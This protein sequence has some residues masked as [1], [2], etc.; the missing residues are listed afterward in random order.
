MSK[1]YGKNITPILEHIA[2]GMWEIDASE[3]LQPYEYG[4][5]ALRAASKIMM[6]VC[7]D[8]LWAKQEAENASR[9]ERY[10]QATA[11]GNDFRKLIKKHL[12]VDPHDF[13][14]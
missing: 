14:K 10:A 12:G 8:K 13:Y 9:E 6:S 7:M 2:N 5:V 3:I 1:E 11:L 4:E